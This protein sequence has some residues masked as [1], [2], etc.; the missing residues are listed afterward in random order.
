MRRGAGRGRPTP[1]SQRRARWGPRG[2][3]VSLG[4]NPAAGDSGLC[5]NGQT[6]GCREAG[7]AHRGGRR[8]PQRASVSGKSRSGTRSPRIG[9]RWHTVHRRVSDSGRARYHQHDLARRDAKAT[10]RN[11]KH[12]PAEEQDD[13]CSS[14]RNPARREISRTFNSAIRQLCKWWPGIHSTRLRLAQ[15]RLHRTADGGAF[16]GLRASFL[17]GFT[18]HPDERSPDMSSL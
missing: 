2:R 11:R 17:R 7:H 13:R 10:L 14:R 1:A 3:L 12:G 8:S 5:R 4:A 9:H 16:Q 15:D 18:P 6:R